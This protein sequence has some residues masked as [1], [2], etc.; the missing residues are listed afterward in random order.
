MEKVVVDLQLGK[1]KIYAIA[2]VWKTK[3]VFFEKIGLN[4]SAF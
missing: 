2:F 4:F 1:W 3:R